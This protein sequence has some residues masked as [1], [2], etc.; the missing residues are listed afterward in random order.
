MATNSIGCAGLSLAHSDMAWSKIGTTVLSRYARSGRFCTAGSM[1]GAVASA[2][3]VA[4]GAL[5]AAVAWFSGRK[6]TAKKL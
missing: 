6:I 1:A 2:A 5:A 3:A 4:A